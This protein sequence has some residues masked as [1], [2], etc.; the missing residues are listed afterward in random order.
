MYVSRPSYIT[1]VAYDVQYVTPASTQLVRTYSDSDYRW[2]LFK[3]LSIPKCSVHI[4][5]RRSTASSMCS[6]CSTLCCLLGLAAA[7]IIGVTLAI[8]LVFILRSNN[9]EDSIKISKLPMKTERFR[10]TLFYNQWLLHLKVII[11][12]IISGYFHG[13]SPTVTSTISK[14]PEIFRV[15]RV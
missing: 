14:S 7:I 12:I 9:D 13:V 10:T 3:I 15:C 4:Y 6:C 8:T 5:R 11:T 1:P 2:I